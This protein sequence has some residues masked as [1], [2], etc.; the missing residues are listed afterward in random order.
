MRE[1][2]AKL[3]E[4]KRL[5][6]D[7][8][9]IIDWLKNNSDTKNLVDHIAISY[10]LQA[11]NYIKKAKRYPE[12]RKERANVYSSIINALGKYQSILEVG[13]GEATTFGHLLPLLSVDTSVVSGGFDISYSRIRYALKYLKDV[14]ITH[15]GLF[16]GDL[17]NAPIQDSSIDVVYTNHTLEPNGGKE[18]EALIEL[19]RITRKYLVLFEPSY[20]LGNSDTK[21]FMQQ[22][23]YVKNLYSTSVKLGYKILEYKLLFEKDSIAMNDNNTGLLIIEKKN[24]VVVFPNMLNTCP[25][26][27]FHKTV[28]SSR[29]KHGSERFLASFLPFFRSSGQ[30][31][32]AR[33]FG[34]L[35]KMLGNSTKKE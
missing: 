27:D 9:N 35:F 3:K 23:G 29:Q 19:Y 6:D 28:S 15:S 18:A 4:L 34:A 11:G 1:D 25:F 10:D 32:Q 13:I 17:F 30:N 26:C 12:Q 22:H 33:E 2:L 8:V 21:A 7:G 20:E 5:F 31:A 24:N 14:G 16:V